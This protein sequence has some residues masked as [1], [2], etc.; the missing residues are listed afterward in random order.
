MRQRSFFR[1]NSIRKIF[2]RRRKIKFQRARRHPSRNT[3][4]NKNRRKQRRPSMHRRRRQRRRGKSRRRR[5]GRRRGRGRRRRRGRGR[6]RRRGRGRGRRRRGRR[7]RRCL[8]SKKKFKRNL[9]WKYLFKKIKDQKTCQSCYISSILGAIEGMHALKFGEYINLSIQEVLDCNHRQMSCRGGIPSYTADYILKYGVA[10]EKDYPYSAK[11]KTC[12]AN[13]SFNKYKVRSRLL[14]QLLRQDPKP[15]LA[16]ERN[17]QSLSIEF[18]KHKKFIIRYDKKKRKLYKEIRLKG[19]PT[20]YVDLFGRHFVPSYRPR[21][22]FQITIGKAE[23]PGKR[24]CQ[25]EGYSIQEVS[26]ELSIREA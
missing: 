12:R 2:A 19:R 1:R 13:Y 15:E 22:R 5:R 24:R 11:K 6:G 18:G 7:R 25:E 20:R 21:D 17:L 14:E 9:S 10:L 26:E 4:R 8:Q 23:A 3:R 16:D